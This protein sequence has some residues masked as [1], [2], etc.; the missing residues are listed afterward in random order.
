MMGIDNSAQLTGSGAVCANDEN[1][2]GLCVFGSGSHNL[3][4]VNHPA[5]ASEGTK[6][7]V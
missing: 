5:L 6:T 3:S 2:R 4:L 1:G 7:A